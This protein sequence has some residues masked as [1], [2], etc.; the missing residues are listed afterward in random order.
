MCGIAGIVAHHWPPPQREEAVGRMVRRLRHRGPDQLQVLSLGAATFATARLAIVD[1]QGGAQPWILQD[2][3]RNRHLLAYNGE[4]YNH[5]QLRSELAG[6]FLSRS[7][8]E[9]VAHAVAQWGPKAWPRIDGMFA[10]AAFDDATRTLRMARDAHGCKP[11]FW[12]AVAGGVAFASEPKALLELAEVDRR[13]DGRAVAQFFGHGA[14]FPA[15][16][17][18]G[19]LSFFAGIAAL[20]PG[21]EV[22]WQVGAPQPVVRRWFDWAPLLQQEPFGTPAQAREALDEAFAAAVRGALMADAKVGATLSGGVDSSMVAAEALRH[23]P[24]E[25]VA[26]TIAFQPDRSDA[27]PLAAR[28][29]CD[30]L[31]A[32]HGSRLVHAWTDM[33]GAEL[34]DPL[35]DLVRTFDGPHWEPRQLGMWRNY[36][37]LHSHGCKAV[38]TGEAADE[39]F[40]G[41]HPRFPGLRPPPP[42]MDNPSDF[43]A[44]WRQ[45]L[46]WA[47]ELLGPAVRNGLIAADEFE[48]QAQNAVGQW[49]APHWQQPEDRWRAV[50][51]WYLQTFL[52]WLLECNDRLGMASSL[53]GRFPFLAQQFVAT[54]LRIPP[55]WCFAGAQGLTDKAPLRQVAGRL[56]PESVWR[57]RPKAPMPT[58][59]QI[60]LHLQIADRL[61]AELDHASPMA[62]E[63]IDVGMAAA[64]VRQ[65]QA[66]V[67]PLLHSDPNGGEAVA[68]YNPNLPVRTVYLFGTLTFLRFLALYAG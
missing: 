35:D 3:R 16:C 65:F 56:L 1:P 27:D 40:F 58:P 36:R 37:T 15:A 43:L 32:Q 21:H 8:T 26:A 55:P 63:W 5:R 33:R 30:H 22:V 31:R 9:T 61:Q 24:G 60:A 2:S 47:Q 20:P 13:I 52:P 38:L 48:A 62:A 66:T 64:M 51:A 44:M 59:P 42:A 29:V 39:L 25:L 17:N 41:Y 12:A 68:R 18:T 54:A 10:I 57:D 67:R 50:Q 7:D 23:L 11:L 28:A 45:R 6:P 34:L 14:A 19:D 46:P 49:L 4:A 53:E